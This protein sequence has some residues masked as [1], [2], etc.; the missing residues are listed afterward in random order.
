MAKR[1]GMPKGRYFFSRAN[2]I[3]AKV[4]EARCN[5][6]RKRGLYKDFYLFQCGC[7]CGVAWTES[8]YNEYLVKD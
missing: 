4:I 7:G 1:K 8:A 3:E 2:M 6:E 5:S